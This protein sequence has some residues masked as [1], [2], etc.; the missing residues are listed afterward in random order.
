LTTVDNWDKV[1]SNQKTKREMKKICIFFLISFIYCL[2]CQAES[3]PVNK[4]GKQETIKTRSIVSSQLFLVAI[5]INSDN[6]KKTC[7][8]DL[9]NP[10]PFWKQKIKMVNLKN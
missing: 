2:T 3:K 10:F 5:N 6:S 1:S 8:F 7:F 4:N 9:T